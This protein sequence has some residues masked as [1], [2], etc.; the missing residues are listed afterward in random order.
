MKDPLLPLILSAGAFLAVLVWRVRPL[1]SWT[2]RQAEVKSA[3]RE[4]QARIE[5]TPEG[6]GRA[7]A[8][9]D[10]ADLLARRTGTRRSAAGFYGR[11]LRSDPTSVDVVQRTVAG[12]GRRPRTLESVLWRHL[13]IVR[14][15]E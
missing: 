11:A 6:P 3:L 12:L 2:Q 9:C 7:C 8:L 15:R 1:V 10:A 13:S 5:G 4:A 14:W